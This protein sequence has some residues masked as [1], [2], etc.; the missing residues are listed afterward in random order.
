MTMVDDVPIEMFPELRKDTVPA[1]LE[2]GRCRYCGGFTLRGAAAGGFGHDHC[3]PT[4]VGITDVATSVAA[5]K[6]AQTGSGSRLARQIFA[7]LQ[8]RG[9]EGAT[10]SELSLVFEDSPMS[11][12]AKRRCDLTR[13][14]LVV[15]SGRTRKSRY[16]RDAIV[17]RVAEAPNQ[18]WGSGR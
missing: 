8:M 3:E 17:W 16:G 12:V 5:G 4:D 14:G 2:G 11:S 7:E 13:E 9:S 6:R 18:P 1:L 15:D 10:D